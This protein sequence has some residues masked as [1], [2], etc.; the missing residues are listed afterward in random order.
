M[1]KHLISLLV[2]FL[3]V[4]TSFV[5]VSNNVMIKKDKSTTSSPE[6][7]LDTST[8]SIEQVTWNTTFH[9]NISGGKFWIVIKAT[10]PEGFS[11]I[12]FAKRC[13]FSANGSSLNFISTCLDNFEYGILFHNLHIY[14]LNASPDFYIQYHRGLF[15]FSYYHE[16]NDLTGW[17]SEWSSFDTDFP[18]T[19]YYTIVSS[20]TECVLDIWVNCSGN[21]TV[22]MT[23]GTDVFVYDR[24][25]FN[26]KINIGWKRG[27]FI[28]KGHKE[29]PINHQLFAWFDCWMYSTGREHLQYT[30]PT[31]NTDWASYVDKKGEHVQTNQSTDFHKNLVWAETGIWSFKINMINMGLEKITPNVFLLGADISL[32]E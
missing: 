14:S 13:R 11:L 20:M 17:G 4:S 2:L 23:T 10:M 25:D 19:W 22:S 27:T 1:K 3:L 16:V 28:V 9:T 31:G 12:Q 5:G 21:A 24:H 18:R 7:S 29:I 6:K 26:G 30:S 15:N 8:S 32:P